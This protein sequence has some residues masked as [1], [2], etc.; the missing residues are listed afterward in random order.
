MNFVAI[1]MIV[2]DRIKYLSLVIGLAFAALLVT[3]QGSIFTGYAL[4][5]GAWI[6][7][8]NVA[9]LWVMD[10][11]VEHTDDFKPMLDNMLQ[12]VRGVDG[13]QWAVPMY[14]AAIKCQLPDGTTQVIRLIGLDDATLT[15]GPHTMA[16][17]ELINLRS[18]RAVFVHVDQADGDLRLKRRGMDRPLAVGDTISINDHQAVVAGMYRSSPEFFWEPVI[19]TTYSRALTMA[20]PER[21]SLTFVLVKAKPGAD[22][23]A[24]AKSIESLMPVRA[25]TPAQFEAQTMD[26]VLKKT[27]ILVNF[28]ITVLLGFIIGVLV[29]GQTLFAFM[30]ENARYFAAIKAMG[31]SNWMIIRMVVVQV[32][33][34]GVLGYGLGIGGACVTGLLFANVGLAFTMSW[35]IPVVGGAAILI[36]CLGAGGIGLIRVLRLE[37]AIVFKG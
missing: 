14:K 26:F 36:C 33:T 24:V 28:G 6:R 2:G 8:T 19:Y 5:T 32:L 29:S 13:V 30:L 10:D 37:P 25:M 9:D 23:A 16:Q 27:G 35:H 3:Q 21:K 17:G 12:R 1:Q 4:R 34:V 7:D 15:G 18:D 11:Q 20:P 22:V 31:A